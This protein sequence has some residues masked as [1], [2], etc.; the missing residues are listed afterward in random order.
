[1]N[2]LPK[3]RPWTPF[4]GPAIVASVAYMDP[5]NF[6]TNVEAG[7]GYGYQL[8][9]VVLSANII[10]MVFQALS[11]K[12]GI[13]T[14]RSLASECRERCPPWAV[15]PMWG[16]SEIAAMATDLAEFLGAAVGFSLLFGLSLSVGLLL[17]GVVTYAFLKM[18]DA[19]F[20]TVEVA[21]ALF[22]AVIALSYLIELAISPPD[23]AAAARHAVVPHFADER[24]VAL[25]A[26]IVGATV[27]PH[28]I[29]LHSNLARERATVANLA[30]T[31]RLV[32]YS[33][34][35]VILAL[36]L[37]GLV[38]MAMVAMSASVF[39]KTGHAEVAGVETAYQ[40]LLPLL[41]G[42]AATVYLVSLLA[43]GV[44]SSA[45]GT[46]AGQAIMQDF[47][48]WRIPLWVR[49]AVTM[50]PP[51]AV[52]A[53]GADATNAL[54]MSQI[55]LSLVLP[56][57]MIALLV[58]TARKDVMG[59]FANGVLTT[60]FA[61]FAAIIVLALNAVLLLQAVAGGVK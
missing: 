41:G 60:I 56:V 49:R 8:L 17:T 57:P 12:L 43:S 22:V 23:W 33:N 10:A 18:Q 16:V 2:L 19:G 45:V 37:A 3:S 7:A 27:M 29:Y 58:F 59:E 47:V 35:E 53:V 26:G 6:A 32:R 34:Y 15:Y 11:A 14:G 48:R 28:A 61:I 42:G 46:M 25:A 50:V 20:W 52:A 51:F 1:M 4:A 9:W 30:E 44:S 13:V 39:H 5:G 21:I 38:N 40:T 55:V 36:G 31:R 24:S 54:V